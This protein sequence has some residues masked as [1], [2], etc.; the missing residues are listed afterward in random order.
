MKNLILDLDTGIDDSIALAYASLNPEINL[1][2][3]TGTYGNVE[4]PQG[5]QNSLD[6]L[7]AMGRTEVP[8]FAGEE[9][10]L[11]QGSFHRHAVSA[12]IHGENGVG[13]VQLPKAKK[14][15]Q[16]E[17]AVDFLAKSMHNYQEDLTIVTTGPLTNLATVLRKDPSLK[18]WKGHIV[19][20]G[21]AL[22]VRGNINHFA[23]ANISQDP[24]AAKLVFE[25]NLDVTMV[26]LD[27]TMRSR[28]HLFQATSWQQ[29]E[30]PRA[31]FLGEMLQYY[32]KN[33]LGTDETYIHDPSAV[34]CALHPEFFTILP[35]YLTVETEGEDRGRTLVDHTRLRDTNPSTKVCIDVESLKVEGS[36]ELILGGRL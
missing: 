24:E 26:G 7:F 18:N 25:S 22:A 10:A 2:G 31:R 19:V 13:Q 29:K 16:E 14:E 4:M 27:V 30:S 35:L 1:L 9:H 20:M 12:R 5:V 23:E 34:I 11:S 17:T 28:L 8:V 15:K 21:G 36:L 3:V 33:T 6:V 32:I